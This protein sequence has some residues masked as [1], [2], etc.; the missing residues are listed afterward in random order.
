MEQDGYLCGW[1]PVWIVDWKLALRIDD[2]SVPLAD[3]GSDSMVYWDRVP[4][5]S[6]STASEIIRQLKAKS[7][8]EAVLWPSG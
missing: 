3:D 7:A 5:L 1:V 2:L 8:A 4:P 6:D